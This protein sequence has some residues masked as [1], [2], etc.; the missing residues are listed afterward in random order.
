LDGQIFEDYNYDVKLTG[1]REKVG[2][3]SNTV[4]IT[5]TDKGGENVTD[6]YLITYDYG[7]L[8]I[9][10]RP[11]T[12][13]AGSIYEEYS[14]GKVLEIAPD[15]YELTGELALSTHFVEAKVVGSLSSFGQS[16]TTVTY[17]K[18]YDKTEN[19]T[20]EVTDQYEITYAT[21]ILRMT[22]PE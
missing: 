18:I 21:G 9:T 7:K 14:S 15:N 17:T 4:K 6:H 5:I 12:I 13:K 20:V 16:Y 1:K 2:T 22:L 10:R 19:E 8:K 3:S 11:I